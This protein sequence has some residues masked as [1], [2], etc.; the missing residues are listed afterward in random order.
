M[1][2]NFGAV[3][4]GLPDAA[5]CAKCDGSIMNDL[6]C[7]RPNMYFSSCS[8]SQFKSALISNG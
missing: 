2:H 8:I 4:D 6:Y 1:G 3:H 7:R 5:G